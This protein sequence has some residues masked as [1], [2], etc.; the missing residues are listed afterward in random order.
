MKHPYEL[1][2]IED[3]HHGRMTDAER[4]AFEEVLADNAG[5][6]KELEAV[7]A[8]E[9]IMA[10]LRKEALME[11]MEKWG[12]EKEEAKR[13]K[14]SGSGKVIPL[15]RRTL[16]AIA[17]SLALIIAAYFLLQSP[18]SKYAQYAAA[19][20]N[21]L[22]G[23]LASPDNRAVA[24]NDSGHYERAVKFF[25]K[26]QY[27][28]VI[29]MEQSDETSNFTYLLALSLFHEKKY[30]AAAE[31]F[32]SITQDLNFGYDAEW[33]EILSLTAQ[34]PAT[35]DILRTKLEAIERDESHHYNKQV[36]SWKTAIDWPKTCP[37]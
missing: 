30:G 15:R 27:Q 7:Q 13:K 14:A 22:V 26:G 18:N 5:L 10:Y 21:T 25:Q 9:D 19:N 29:D 20:I 32:N 37:Q 28:K 4:I 8:Q 17:A 6:Q 2:D 11:E 3:Y 34:L 12:K 16:L 33:G 35:C 31:K 24:P 1:E 36:S 23:T